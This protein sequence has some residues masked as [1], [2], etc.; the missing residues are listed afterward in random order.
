[1]G[2][3]CRGLKCLLILEWLCVATAA[4][5]AEPRFL[6]AWSDG[7]RTAED[8]VRDWQRVASRPTLGRRPLLESKNHVRWLFDTQA[9]DNARLGSFV[10]FALGDRLPGRVVGYSDNSGLGN[11]LPM[12]L[13]RP[14]LAID[15]PGQQ[16]PELPVRLDFVRRIVLRAQGG[17]P[18][19]PGSLV[20]VDGR[21]IAFRS[22]RFEKRGVRVLTT[23]GPLTFRFDELVEIN[24]PL[25]KPFESL[26]RALAVLTPD[27][28]ARLMRIETSSGARITTSLERLQARTVRGD[29]PQKWFHLVQPAWSLEA[30][31]IPHRQIR[32]RVFT[33][34]A[35]LPLSWLEPLAS[36]HQGFFSAAWSTAQV[37]R[38]V[39]QGMLRAAGRMYCFGFGVHAEHELEFELPA[40][41]RAFRTGLAL[42]QL[43]AGGGCALGRIVIEGRTAYESPVLVGSAR[44][45]ESGAL[46]LG[47]G[48]SRR[49]TLVADACRERPAGADPFDIRDMVDWL[50]PTVELDRDGLRGEVERC[51]SQALWSTGGWTAD[52]LENGS[53][54][55]VYTF[56][57]A[58]HAH[59]AY[60]PL[61]EFGT[62]LTLNQRVRVDA[63][64]G[65]ATL[66]FG[67]TRGTPDKLTFEITVAG[68]RIVAEKV[69]PLLKSGELNKVVFPLFG[70][71]GQEVDV[72]IRFDPQGKKA[73]IDCRALTFTPKGP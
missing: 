21:R 3:R 2:G 27:L 51:M 54:R 72:A 53:W 26:F 64:H 60:R 34:P 4:P 12:L 18:A 65:M 6:A 59:P 28:S 10:E 70:L 42:D 41:A 55:V 1:M 62:P 39:R 36:R 16:R 63:E 23:V 50:E 33:P 47:S 11:S 68:R 32:L 35:E 29:E 5:A 37:D 71:S 58:D 24:L 15:L 67:R 38:N 8:E 45:V 31:A 25:D 7:S 14:D 17:P 30:L 40:C 56:S 46:P 49:L 69:P 44:V 61:I 73:Q 57:D 66:E 52:P 9:V 20:A 22:L 19:T 43:V 48:V 13:V